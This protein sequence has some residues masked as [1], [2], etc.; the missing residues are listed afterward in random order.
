MD[1]AL[2]L[3]LL[4]CPLLSLFEDEEIEAQRDLME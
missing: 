3:I 1:K 2:S 4:F